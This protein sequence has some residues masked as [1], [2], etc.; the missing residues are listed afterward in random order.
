MI[1]SVQRK[2]SPLVPFETFKLKTKLLSFVLSGWSNL[3]EMLNCLHIVSE[4]GAIIFDK[5]P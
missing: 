1:P 4:V 2:L 3:Q 5:R